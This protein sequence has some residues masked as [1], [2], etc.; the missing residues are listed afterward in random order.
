MSEKPS[1]EPD[2]PQPAQPKGNESKD[3]AQLTEGLLKNQERIVL[4][5][6]D[7]LKNQER[8]LELREK[9]ASSKLKE[10]WIPLLATI[11]TLFGILSG[12]ILSTIDGRRQERLKQ[13]EVTF[14]RK[15][16]LYASFMRHITESFHA[17]RVIDGPGLDRSFRQLEAAY[18]GMEPF[19][20]DNV[21]GEV[22]NEV[23]SFIQYCKDE[24]TNNITGKGSIDS[25]SGGYILRRNKLRDRLYPDL[26]RR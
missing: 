10:I 17:T 16:E 9:G 19:L 26:F 24:Y 4:L 1:R 14:Q 25:Q 20:S 22:E 5:A 3:F 23:R 8:N 15:Q 11:I 13:L 12:A 7:F 21:R 2:S 18:H 6:E